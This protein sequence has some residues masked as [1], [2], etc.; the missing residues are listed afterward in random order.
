LIPVALKPFVTGADGVAV[1]RAAGNLIVDLTLHENETE[2]SID[3]DGW[4]D[5]LAS[6]RGD[7]L[8]G[9][10]RLSISAG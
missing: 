10:L 5:T 6:L 2:D 8:E 1:R 9:D 4:L 7:I 3:G